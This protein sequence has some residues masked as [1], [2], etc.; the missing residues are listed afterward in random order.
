[1]L[2]HS[3]MS[4]APK[5]PVWRAVASRPVSAMKRYGLVFFRPSAPCF[6][7]GAFQNDFS[8]VFP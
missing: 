2:I 8:A 6:T 7:L 3:F 4:T 1:M 5:S